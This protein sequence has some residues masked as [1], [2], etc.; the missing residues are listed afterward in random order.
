M[1]QYGDQ[2]KLEAGTGKEVSVGELQMASSSSIIVKGTGNKISIGDG[3]TLNGVRILVESNHSE[4]VVGPNSRIS[5]AIFLKG[6]GSNSVRIG[7]LTSIGGANII[8]SEGSSF[9]CGRDCMFAWGIEVRTTDSH[10][11]FDTITGDRI[12]HA[13]DIVIGEHV[14]IAAKATILKGTRIAN[15]CAVGISSVV[16]GVFDEPQSLIVGNPARAIRQNIRWTREL[17]G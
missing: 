5:G 7:A 15:G 8:C 14:W 1:S 2:L 16:T 17:L 6:K 4:I 10:G 3:C 9:S 13:K 12:N 11:I